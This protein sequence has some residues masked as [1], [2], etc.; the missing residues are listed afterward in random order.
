MPTS[1]AEHDFATFIL[2]RSLVAGEG[3]FS[4]SFTGRGIYRPEYFRYAGTAL[5]YHLKIL[6]GAKVEKFHVFNDLRFRK[7]W[8]AGI[9]ASG[10]WDD[11]GTPDRPCVPLQSKYGN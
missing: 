2:C 6:E 11:V 9:L 7:I 10:E 5:W 8:P 4:F 3:I 1:L